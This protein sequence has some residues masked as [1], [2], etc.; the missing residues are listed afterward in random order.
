MTVAGLFGA[1][2]SKA[3]VGG[4]PAPEGRWPW[5]A[6]VLTAD[7]R[8]VTEAQYCGGVVIAR[9]RVLTAAHCVAERKADEVDVLIG[10]T[11][12]SETGGRRLRVTG[13]SVF[14]G[15]ESGRQASLDAAVLTLGADAGVPPVAL[16]R[17]GQDAAASPGTPAWTIGWGALNRRQ[18]PGDNWYYA[19]RLRELQVPVQGDDACEN[20]YG[21]GAV[22]IPY[23][24]AWVRCAG[25][26]DGRSGACFGDS[27]APLVVGGPGSWLDVGILIGGD[28]CASRGYFDLYA[29][30]DQ[31]SAFAL[32]AAMTSRPEPVGRPRIAGRLAVG[33]RVLCRRGRWHGSRARFT[34]R[35][36][37]LGD[38]SHRVLGRHTAYR[39]SRRDVRSGVTCAITAANHGGHTTVVARPLRPA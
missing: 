4:S 30:V 7:I 9:R 10:R 20:A 3:I 26:A 33:G 2:T 31:I 1:T 28:S 6:A 23:R 14:P 29:R 19:D 11:R 22:N 38:R 16:A 17:P 15:Y 39:L 37:R 24:P 18:S 21:I 5:M 34:V 32:G 13:I 8:D 35:W 25:A 12:L 27:G 36:G